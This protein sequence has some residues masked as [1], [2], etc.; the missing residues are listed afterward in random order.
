MLLLT[1]FLLLTIVL[2]LVLD[3]WAQR[4]A[5]AEV[6]RQSRQVK[7]AFN[8]SFGDFAQAVSLGLQSLGSNDYLYEVTSRV[9]MPS[10]LKDIIVADD[11]G[12]VKDTTL[13]ELLNQYIKVPPPPQ[14]ITESQ[15]IDPVEGE[16]EI[17][18]GL[19]KTYDIPILTQKGLHWI[20]IVMQQEA[21]INQIDEAQVAL[22]ENNRRLSN[23]RLGGTTGLLS[24]ALGI[25]VVIGWRFTKPI[26][27]LA[28]AAHRVASGDLDFRVGINR[29]DEVGQLATTFN[30]MIAGLKTK[31][32]LE[33]RL[34]LSERA[35]VIGR[36]TQAIAH[37]IRNPLNV[38]NL[39]VD[40]VR[41]KYAPEDEA[42]AK[43]FTRLLSS[44]KDEI[45]R[46][47]NMV[48]DVLNFGRPAHL[49]VEKININD[50]M[51]ETVQLVRPQA[52]EQGVEITFER[53]GGP[54]EVMGDPERLKSCLSNITINAL[55]AMPAGGMLLVRVHSPDGKVEV[56]VS[57]TGLGISP[58]SINKVFEPYFSTK[59]SGFGL[60]LA[61]TKKI[62]EEHHG[63]IE[64]RSQVNRGTTFT[65]KF[66]VA[67]V[68]SEKD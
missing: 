23:Y 17:E 55:Q 25:A 41:A 38:I 7:G 30:E 37:E 43:Q 64:V 12:K 16:V 46:L 67:G 61:V 15:N 54:A 21:I 40:Q 65:M 11:T 50:L 63:S 6:F 35:A 8:T 20:V 36:L 27:E 13:P 33:E 44:V 28:G 5:S 10:T 14:G 19:I 56:T 1:S 29:R 4:R 62:V 66:P 34:S 48:N 26:E 24:F 47:R 22:A 49:S 68:V 32:E 60:G 9:E 18:G 51:E 59:K 52:E 58:E 2:V 42:R 57:D 31:L 3:R 45:A 39:S 53:D